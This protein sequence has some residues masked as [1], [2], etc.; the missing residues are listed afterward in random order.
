MKTLTE[1]ERGLLALAVSLKGWYVTEDTL[2]AA[3]HLVER[4]LCSASRD[5]DGIQVHG[6]EAGEKLAK[7]LGLIQ[8]ADPTD[9]YNRS[10]WDRTEEGR[11]ITSDK[12]LRL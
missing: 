12:N 8:R 7:R 4:G 5:Y 6:T 10:G 1:T 3:G 11:R 9:Y 2:V